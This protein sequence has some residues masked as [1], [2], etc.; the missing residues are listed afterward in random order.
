LPDGVAGGRHCT[1][2]SI[3]KTVDE[4]DAGEDVD[5]RIAAG[6]MSSLVGGAPLP[7][8]SPRASAGEGGGTLPLPAA[9]R[10]GEGFGGGGAPA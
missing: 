1:A 2:P 10:R 3:V 8:P 4:Q 5:Q 6:L 9:W 7:K